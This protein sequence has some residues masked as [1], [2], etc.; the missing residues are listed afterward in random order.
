MFFSGADFMVG[1]HVAKSPRLDDDIV[2]GE[3]VKVRDAA[4]EFSPVHS[5]HRV[6]PFLGVSFDSNIFSRLFGTVA[7]IGGVF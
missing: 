7:K 3:K 2:L 4:A 1:F 5:R 6:R